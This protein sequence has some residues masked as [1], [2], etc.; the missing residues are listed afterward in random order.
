V[1]R[2]IFTLASVPDMTQVRQFWACVSNYVTGGKQ[3]NNYVT[4][5]TIGASKM[6]H[7]ISTHASCYSSERVGSDE[8]HFNAYHFAIGDTSYQLLKSWTNKLSLADLHAAMKLRYPIPLSEVGHGYL[9]LEQKTLVEYG[10]GASLSL[11]G[12]ASK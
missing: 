1:I 9:S 12:R 11:R 10:Y 8:V 3:Q 5:S 6:C 7:S 4:S 2:D